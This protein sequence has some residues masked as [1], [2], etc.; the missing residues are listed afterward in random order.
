M[1]TTTQPL[2]GHD[3]R[4]IPV[5]AVV[6]AFTPGAFDSMPLTCRVFAENMLRRSDPER[7]SG[8]LAQVVGRRSDADFSFFPARV[9]LQDVL[10]TT[11]LVDLA[12]LREA[13]AE[14]KGDPARVNP[15]VPAQLVVDHSLNVEVGGMEGDALP[16]NMAIERRKNAER[17]AFLAWAKRAFSN[18]E[19]VMP[20]N[21]ILHQINL[22]RLSPVIQVQD[23]LAFVDTL[24]GTDS[25]TTMINALGVVGW[26]VGGIEAESVMLGRPI[27]MRLPEIVGVELKGA[28]QTGVQATDLVL[29]LTEYLRSESVVGCIL[30]FYGDGVSR[31]SLADRATIANMAPEY[32][33]TAA[34]FA[35]DE[36]TLEFLR[37]TGR[38]P[39]Q[40]QTGR[41][42]CPRPGAVG[43]VPAAG[44]IHAAPE[45]RSRS[46]WARLGGA[47]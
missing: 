32:G 19:V 40:V 25:H 41:V 6:E 7:V 35:I 3:L 17:F 14:A 18:V 5:R 15:L 29:A 23:G 16:L 33:A 39:E 21:G 28:R 30:E 20:G 42:L 45:L 2:D 13:V 47:G 38:R 43:R 46:R 10:G 11:A 1:P 36:R 44:R 37:L 9:V 31:L 24:V 22:E 4:I 12:G 26:G 34:M 27:W 8:F